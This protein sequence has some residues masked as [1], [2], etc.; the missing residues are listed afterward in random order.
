[1][2]I[3]HLNCI[4][5]CPLGGRLMDGRTE[6]ILRRGRLTCHCLLAETSAGLVL[7]DT[8]FGLRDVADPASR[9]SRFFLLLLR[10]E[11]RAQMTAFRQIERMGLDPRDVRHIVMTHLDFDHAGGMDDFPDADIHLM[12]DEADHARLQKTWLD[13]ARFRPRQWSRQD[14]WRLYHPDRGE[15]WFGFDR[16]QVLDGLPPDILMIP[17]P[18]HTFGHAGVALRHDGRWLLQAGDAYFHHAEMDLDAPRCTLGLRFY[19]WMMEKDRAQRLGNQER[20]RDLK[21][22]HGAEVD[23]LCSHDVDEFERHSGRS[24]GI[25]AEELMT[26]GRR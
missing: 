4:S 20:L 6:T 25:P 1:M 13:R 23:V 24:A 26:S 18:G 7:V 2:R 9:L 12:A 10:P 14:R 17:L 21:R 5:T 15:P 22:A 11:F 19:Q 16:V 3:H 8:G